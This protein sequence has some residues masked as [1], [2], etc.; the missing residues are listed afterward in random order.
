MNDR[1]LG[2]TWKGA[3]DLSSCENEFKPMSREIQEKP[4][5]FTS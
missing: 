3:R 5:T 2:A 4:F 1:M